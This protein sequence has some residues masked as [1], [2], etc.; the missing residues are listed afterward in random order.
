MLFINTI[1]IKV[2]D[3]LLL[4][5]IQEKKKSERA[6]GT[7]FLILRITLFLNTLVNL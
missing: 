1:E 4:Y 2:M 3:I 6:I 7:F 5:P